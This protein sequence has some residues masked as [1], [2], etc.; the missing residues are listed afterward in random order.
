MLLVPFSCFY[1]MRVSPLSGVHVSTICNRH[2]KGVCGGNIHAPGT[3]LLSAG[4]LA[5]STSTVVPLASDLLAA[6]FHAFSFSSLML[7]MIV[8][9]RGLTVCRWTV[10]IM[11]VNG[12][13]FRGM[14]ISLGW[15][16]VFV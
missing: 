16:S 5:M 9:G 3:R 1:E 4:V 13:F 6:I 11:L 15:V 7:S 8:S 14:T 12:L 10:L 2:D